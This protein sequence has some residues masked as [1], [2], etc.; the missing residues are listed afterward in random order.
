[1]EQPPPRGFGSHSDAYQAILQQLSALGRVVAY[2]SEQGGPGGPAAPP[3]GDESS[4]NPNPVV[5]RDGVRVLDMLFDDQITAASTGSADVRAESVDGI[6]LRDVFR[7]GQFP[8]SVV[9]TMVAMAVRDQRGELRLPFES[10]EAA[11]GFID[12]LMAKK[13]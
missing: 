13:R 7:E 9:K 12:A 11:M 6:A 1:M 5:L 8:T 3:P 10:R 2:L 4:G